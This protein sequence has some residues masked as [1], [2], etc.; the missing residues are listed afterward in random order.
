MICSVTKSGRK[1]IP[2][3]KLREAAQANNFKFVFE[4][5]LD[6]LFSAEFL[7]CFD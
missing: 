7:V 1:A 2:D 4:K 3:E 5:A 6:G